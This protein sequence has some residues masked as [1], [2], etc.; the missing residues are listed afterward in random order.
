MKRVLCALAVLLALVIG[1]LAW[2]SRAAVAPPVVTR[3]ADSSTSTPRGEEEPVGS[4]SGSSRAP[5]EPEAH[6]QPAANPADSAAGAIESAGILVRGTMRDEQGKPAEKSGL[7]W[8]ESS[9]V[10]HFGVCTDG[11]YSIAGLR[12][13]HYLVVFGGENYRREE[14]PV[15][16]AAAPEVQRYDFVVHPGMRFPIRIVDSNGVSLLPK[17]G[18]QEAMRAWILTVH[19]TRREPTG[20]VECLSPYTNQNS[21]CGMF[22]SSF[23]LE[24]RHEVLGAGVLGMLALSERPPL[25]VSLAFGS[26]VVASRRIEEVPK[27]LVFTIEPELLRSRLAGVRV[28]LVGADHKTPAAGGSVMLQAQSSGTLSSKTD[29]DGRVEFLE[30]TPGTYELWL[31]AKGCSMQSRRAVLVP[32][33]V[34]DLGDVVLSEGPSLKVRFEFPGSERSR[35]VFDLVPSQPDNPLGSLDQQHGTLLSTGDKGE[36]I[37]PF[38]GPGQYDLRIATGGGPGTGAATHIGALPTRVLLGDT[39][40]EVIVVRLEVTTTVTLNPP[41]D[42]RPGVRWLIST[43]DG[44]PVKLVRIEGTQ[45]KLVELPRG[46]YSVVPISAEERSFDPSKRQHFEVGAEPSTVELLP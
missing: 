19:A 22:L 12:A 27:E 7:R 26:S 14:L 39:P 40:P 29:D 44:R 23:L 6:A 21:E 41:K 38:P 17:E 36:S 8:V 45:P 20:T 3:S 37:L 18:D 24:P 31:M 42:S 30:R 25:Y 11:E 34:L 1:W 9:G 4:A 32:G 13:G 5:L 43:S 33:E 16:L 35:I 2:S 28:R 10:E 15:D 46:R